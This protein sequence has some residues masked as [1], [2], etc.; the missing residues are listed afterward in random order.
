MDLVA[1]YAAEST[2]WWEAGQGDPIG[3]DDK[4]QKIDGEIH[5]RKAPRIRPR[6]QPKESLPPGVKVIRISTET[7]NPE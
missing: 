3:A 2:V 1:K 6:Q 5:E 7:K 4:T